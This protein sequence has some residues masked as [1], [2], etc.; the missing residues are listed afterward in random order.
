MGVQT[1][2]H[3]VFGRL[4]FVFFLPRFAKAP[5]LEVCYGWLWRHACAPDFRQAGAVGTL[6]LEKVENTPLKLTLKTLSEIVFFFRLCSKGYV[7]FRDGKLLLKF[8]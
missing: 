4:G 1:P 2:T 3:K 8:V 5:A 7:S 6:V